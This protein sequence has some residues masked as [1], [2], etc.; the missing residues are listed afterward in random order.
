MSVDDDSVDRLA[1]ETLRRRPYRRRNRLV[2]P[3]WAWPILGVF[4]LLLGLVLGW[5]LWRPQTVEET[6]LPSPTATA[7]L[8][9]SPTSTATR[10]ATATHSVTPSPTY[11]GTPPPTATVTDTPSPT[12]S[13]TPT[14][15]IAVGGRV[16]VS[17]VGTT[18]LRLRSGPGVDFITFKIIEEGTILE[19][20]GGPEKADNYTWWRLKDDKGV[21]GW[22]ASDW[23]VPVP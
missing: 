12:A 9:V 15:T 2:L 11:T 18:G 10:L 23:L 3:S 20:L 21:I 7:T 5:L 4:C 6:P 1:D 22:A 13:A 14:M 16:K 8:Q 19:V 17:G